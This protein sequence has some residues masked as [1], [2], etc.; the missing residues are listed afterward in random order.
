MKKFILILALLSS[1]ITFADEIGVI[2]GS[3]TGVSAKFNLPTQN[4]AIDVGLGYKMNSTSSLT[5]Q[6]DYLFENARF[7]RVKTADVFAMYYGLGARLININSDGVNKG[8][9]SF[10]PRAPI[11]LE[12][13]INNPDISVFGELAVAVDLIP[14]SLV[15]LQAGLGVRLRF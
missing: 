5:L 6:A 8:K 4:R 15:E 7:I 2:L 11:G 9:T 14:D 13:K 1:Q 12:Y 3:T 10:G